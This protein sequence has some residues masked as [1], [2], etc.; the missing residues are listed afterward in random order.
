MNAH[1][2]LDAIYEYVKAKD[3]QDLLAD[4]QDDNETTSPLE[5][6]VEKFEEALKA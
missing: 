3:S 1:A 5:A 4:F 6:I 2:A